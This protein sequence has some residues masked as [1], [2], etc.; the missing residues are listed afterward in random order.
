MKEN[1]YPNNIW[2]LVVY[3]IFSLF[4]YQEKIKEVALSNKHIVLLC[5]DH[6]QEW[7]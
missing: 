4:F 2:V 1:L 7:S 6:M 3:Y 5:G